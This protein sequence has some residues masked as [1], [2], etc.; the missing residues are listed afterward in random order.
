M[1]PFGDK[2][3]MK[4]LDLSKEVESLAKKA[5]STQDAT[6][7]LKFS[8]SACNLAN[9]ETCI[10]TARRLETETSKELKVD[11]DEW[12]EQHENLLTVKDQD[13]AALN[14]KIEKLESVLGDIL[15]AA[16]AMYNEITDRSQREPVEYI[17]N[18][19]AKILGITGRLPNED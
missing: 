4:N 1:R 16:E 15:N 18:S 17:Y 12:R 11:R 5:D 7:A 9:A 19:A 6:D 14:S 8:Q 2:T 10:T 13:N 3:Q